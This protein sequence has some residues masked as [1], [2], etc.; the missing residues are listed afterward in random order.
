MIDNNGFKF[1]SFAFALFLS[2]ENKKY[3]KLLR[4]REKRE[5]HVTNFLF[6]LKHFS[7]LF[8]LKFDR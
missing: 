3:R 4:V 6:K 1:C 8:F 7:F 2:I 5:K